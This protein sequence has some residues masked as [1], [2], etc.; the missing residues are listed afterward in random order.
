MPRTNV[1]Q[2]T[3]MNAAKCHSTTSCIISS[4][5]PMNW[6]QGNSK[7]IDRRQSAHL[8]CHHMPQYS[9]SFSNVKKQE[10]QW[11]CHDRF[12]LA[13][14]LHRYKSVMCCPLHVKTIATPQGT[15]KYNTV[16]LITNQRICSCVVHDCLASLALLASVSM[17]LPDEYTDTYYLIIFY[18]TQQI[19]P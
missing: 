1:E 18:H 13:D 9:T 19:V 15:L 14:E 7:F 4:N 11:F 10:S 17:L 6:F 2:F 12:V 3:L 16:V 8:C 5:F